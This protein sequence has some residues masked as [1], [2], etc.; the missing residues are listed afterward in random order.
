MVKI[1]GN[2]TLFESLSPGQEDVSTFYLDCGRISASPNSRSG[3]NASVF[4]LLPYLTVG[5]RQEV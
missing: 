2:I 4:D 3:V 5:R 1:K